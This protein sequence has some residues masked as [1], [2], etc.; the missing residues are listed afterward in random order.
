M[1]FLC[2]E[3]GR[4]PGT[5][6]AYGQCITHGLKYLHATGHAAIAEEP[7]SYVR[8]LISL[9]QREAEA[10]RDKSWQDL[11]SRRKWLHWEEIIQVV[12]EQRYC[13]E[14]QISP[15]ER[16]IESQDYAILLLYTTIPPARAQEYRTLKL[17][18]CSGDERRARSL[19]DRDNVLHINRDGSIASLEIRSY[20]NSAY[21]GRQSVDISTVDYLVPHLLDFIAK[22]RPILLGTRE[23]QHNLFLV[24]FS[25][26]R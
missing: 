17:N 22:D 19:P 20:K 10:N 16:A 24:K 5:R 13:Y 12:K 14:S 2:Q 23:D 15:P 6:A 1:T 8:Q 21:L 3:S 7:I 11:S 26:A 25:S 9:Y 4:K 18:L